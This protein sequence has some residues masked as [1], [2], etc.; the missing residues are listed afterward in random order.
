M[1]ASGGAVVHGDNGAIVAR[2]SRRGGI[3]WLRG[4]LKHGRFSPLRRG[5]GDVGINR[6]QTTVKRRRQGGVVWWRWGDSGL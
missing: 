6:R 1:R 4:G 3:A 2:Q 5:R